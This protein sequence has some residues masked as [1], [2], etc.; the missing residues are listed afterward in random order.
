MPNHYSVRAGVQLDAAATSFVAKVTDAFFAATA[1]DITVTSA[2]RGP[3]EQ[4]EAMY[5]KMGGSEWNIYADKTALTEIRG[6]YLAG[7]AAKDDRATIV[8][9][10]TAVIERQTGQGTYISNHLRATALDFRTRDLTTDEIAALRKASTD[11]GATVVIDEGSPPH[12][13]VQF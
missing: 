5:V 12:L 11:S 7:K 4:A 9:A 2:Y 13:H 10:M 3:Q 1:K 8:A 6:V